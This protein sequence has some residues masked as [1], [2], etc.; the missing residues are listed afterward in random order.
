MIAGSTEFLIFH[1]FLDGFS[2][3]LLCL[4]DDNTLAECQTVRLDDN[5]IFILFLNISNRL[6]RIVK[7][8]IL[9][10]RNMILLHEVLGKDFTALDNSG[11]GS[12]TKGTDTICH[13]GIH[14][15]VC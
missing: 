15:A 10:R 2:R 5:G 8:F 12:G 7:G 6:G 3:F 14:H 11:F 9:R 1:N 13:Q 4:S